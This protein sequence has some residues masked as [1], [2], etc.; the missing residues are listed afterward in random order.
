MTGLNYDTAATEQLEAIY[1]GPDIVGQRAQT[2]RILDPKPGEAVLDIGSG[3][4][5]LCSEIAPM[6]GPAGRVRGIDISPVMVERST[7]RKSG[8]WVSFAVG[9]ATDLQEDDATYDAVVS[10]Q[11]AEYVADIGKFCSEALRVLKPG[12]RALIMAT[13]WEAIAWHSRQPERMRRVLAAFAPHCADSALPRTLGKRLRDAGFELGRVTPYPIFNP[14]WRDDSYSCRVI[15][16]ISSYVRK[17]KAMPDED[18]DAWASEQ[19]ELGQS[20]EYYF[21]STRV[22]FEATKPR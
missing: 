15:P 11:V 21:L 20:G 3:P 16:F 8:S 2:L 18:L 5:F 9:D 14:V 4:G 19:A 6:V 13:D 17:A 12:G 1:R 10:I 7:A 22:F